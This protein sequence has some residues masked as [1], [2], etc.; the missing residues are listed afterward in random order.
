LQ[1]RAD[2][3]AENV[4][5]AELGAYRHARVAEMQ[6]RGRACFDVEFYRQKNAD[7]PAVMAA[8]QLWDH[9]LLYGQ[10]EGRQF[11]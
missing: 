4:W 5:Q 8:E 10:F 1:G 9:F 2:A 11:R 3:L 7:L 6:L